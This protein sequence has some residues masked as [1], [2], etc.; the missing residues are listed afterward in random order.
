MSSLEKD[1]SRYYQLNPLTGLIWGDTYFSDTSA[2]RATDYINSSLSTTLPLSLINNTTINS[3]NSSLSA[4]AIEY[5]MQEI[6][7]VVSH[8]TEASK[9]T[10]IPT[11][12]REFNKF[13]LFLFRGIFIDE[14]VTLEQIDQTGAIMASLND[15]VSQLALL[16][17]QLNVANIAEK[18]RLFICLFK[19]SIFTTCQSSRAILM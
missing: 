16:L 19:Y 5:K 11:I 15:T 2:A 17:S 4:L 1:C 12:S 3:L 8:A 7:R 9:S 10:A 14:L 18:V 13:R 6:Q